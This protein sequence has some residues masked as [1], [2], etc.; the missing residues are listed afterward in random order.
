M[1]IRDHA[2]FLTDFG[3]TTVAPQTFPMLLRKKPSRCSVAPPQGCRIT[4]RCKKLRSL[5]LSW[6][7]KIESPR[8]CLL[9]YEKIDLLCDNR[10]PLYNKMTADKP[11]RSRSC[12]RIHRNV[13][14]CQ[15]GIC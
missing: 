6:S 13:Y 10:E 7:I 1:Y 14:A 2:R 8:V 12:A 3:P 5:K 15:L 9:L 4:R 11:L